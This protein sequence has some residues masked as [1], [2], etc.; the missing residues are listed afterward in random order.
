MVYKARLFMKLASFF[1][2]YVFV[3]YFFFSLALIVHKKYWNANERLTSRNRTLVSHVKQNNVH[4]HGLFNIKQSS[5]IHTL[6]NLSTFSNQ[7][8]LSTMLQYRTR[9]VLVQFVHLYSW[10]RRQKT[11]ENNRPHFLSPLDRNVLLPFKGFYWSS[12]GSLFCLRL[13]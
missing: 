3:R 4:G 9:L 10:G 2:I 13:L 12:V 6:W 1:V 5:F 8:I 7:L 11:C